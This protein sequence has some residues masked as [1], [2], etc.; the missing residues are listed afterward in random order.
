LT[1][2]RGDCEDYA[3]VKYV[4][5]LDAGIR[6]EDVKL[7]VVHDILRNEDHA[8][9]VTRVDG[10]WIALDNRWLALVRHSELK[11][12]TPMFVLD[13]NGVRAFVPETGTTKLTD[14][15]DRAILR[16]PE[17]HDGNAHG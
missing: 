6:R 1:T 14:N 7:V 9:T 13:D 11:H 10:D 12:V 16:T 2:G 15:F 3:I 5:L 17:V 4:A 8:I